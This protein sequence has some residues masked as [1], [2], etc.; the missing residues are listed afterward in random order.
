MWVY[1]EGNQKS[2]CIYLRDSEDKIKAT[3]WEVTQKVFVS[4][5]RN[6]LEIVVRPMVGS[7]F[8]GTR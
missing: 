8:S 6:Y 3:K 1:L 2:E 4:N 5:T 7:V